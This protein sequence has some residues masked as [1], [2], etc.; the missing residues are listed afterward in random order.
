M[1][2]SVRKKKKPPDRVYDDEA[3]PVG[4]GSDN[5]VGDDEDGGA[6]MSAVSERNQ[7]VRGARNINQRGSLRHID[8]ITGWNEAI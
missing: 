6:L 3:R 8:K 4:S 1:A 2:S 5:S 7:H